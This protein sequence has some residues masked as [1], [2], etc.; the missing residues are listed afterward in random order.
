MYEGA[1]L[2]RLRLGNAYERFCLERR[3]L[4]FLLVR[5]TRD[6][7][8]RGVLT[9]DASYCEVRAVLADIMDRINE[10]AARLEADERGIGGGLAWACAVFYVWVLYF[11]GCALLCVCIV[12]SDRQFLLW[13][14]SCGLQVWIGEWTAPATV[15]TATPT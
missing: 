8:T 5:R 3:V 6:Y 4:R 12:G 7:V 9:R 13:L 10:D 2:I 15:A 11:R 14:T 1:L